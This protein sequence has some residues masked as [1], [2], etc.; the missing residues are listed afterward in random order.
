MDQSS[1][2]PLMRW[3][4]SSCVAHPL[5]L[6]YGSFFHR[7]T[8]SEGQSKPLVIE[9][10]QTHFAADLK[11]EVTLSSHLTLK[12][13][14]YRFFFFY[15]LVEVQKMKKLLKKLQTEHLCLQQSM[16][17]SGIIKTR[18]I[19]AYLPSTKSIVE[20]AK[21]G[22]QILLLKHIPVPNA[23]LKWGTPRCLP[24]NLLLCT[25]NTCLMQIS[26]IIMSI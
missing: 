7:H 8:P 25:L 14:H 22:L 20:K 17:M 13:R 21:R 4:G 6:A 5:L 10:K 2:Q 16:E 23:P 15:F 26:E 19:K 18:T 9:E 3:M 11:A 1:N 24:C 12:F